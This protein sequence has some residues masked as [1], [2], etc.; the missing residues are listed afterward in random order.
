MDGDS[1]AGRLQVFPK[2]VRRIGKNSSLIWHG[3]EKS[4]ATVS[5]KGP[6]CNITVEVALF[7]LS[8]PKYL[9]ADFPEKRNKMASLM[10]SRKRSKSHNKL[11]AGAKVSDREY[12]KDC[13]NDDGAFVAGPH[14]F[15]IV[16]KREG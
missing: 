9:R 4:G 13:R 5:P 1:A 15:G 11:K 8:V 10:R 3:M 2:K 7:R 12:A 16:P 6:E 14:T